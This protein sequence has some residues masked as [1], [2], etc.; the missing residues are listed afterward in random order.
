M[1]SLILIALGILLLMPAVGMAQEN[2]LQDARVGEWAVYA[3]GDRM[4]ERHSVTARRRS[5]VIVKVDKIINGRVISSNTEEWDVDD[6]KNFQG[7]TGGHQISAG[8]RTYTCFA[9]QRGQRTFYYSNEV[10]VTGLVAIHRGSEVI[11][12]VVNY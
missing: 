5:V 6:P 11:K 9:V 8:G 10:P 3:T 4:Q 1:R 7:A 12:E 2:T